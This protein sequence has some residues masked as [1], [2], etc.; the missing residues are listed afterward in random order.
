MRTVTPIPPSLQ[1]GAITDEFS[2]DPV[3]ALEAMA[4]LGMTAV[5]LRVVEGRNIIELDESELDGLKALA[6]ARGMRVVSIASPVLKCVLPDG[7]PVDERIQQDVFGSQYGIEDQPALMT[8]ALAAARRTG[9]SIVRVFSYWRTTDPGRSF[10]QVASALR[11]LAERAAQEDVIVGLENEHAC[12]IA[13]G[14]ETGRLLAAVNHPA[15]GAIWDPANAFV[16]GEPP[17]PEGYGHVPVARIV[18]VHAKDCAVPRPFTPEW[19]PIGEMGID[20]TGQIR[21]LVTDGYRG[22]INLETHW[23]GPDGNKFEASRICGANLKRLV[24]AAQ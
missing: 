13:T 18:H 24:A 20:W 21:A 22:C 23:R 10:D 14:A 19:G 15:L 2:P 17:F 4:A 7:P 9:A 16:A 3:V 5:E 1:L 6:A 11:A 12:N 8:R